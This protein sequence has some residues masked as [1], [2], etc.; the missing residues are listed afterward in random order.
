[1]AV[2]IP[3]DQDRDLKQ[4][5][6]GLLPAFDICPLDLVAAPSAAAPGRMGVRY[7]QP[8]REL[9]ALT[10]QGGVLRWETGASV[11]QF[12]VGGARAGG[13]AALPSG[14][15]LHQFVFE[16]LEPSRIGQT[17]R[18]LDRRLTPTAWID[19][20][21]D[22]GI[23]QG[24]R[25]VQNGR[26][27]AV[28][29]D[30]S[31]AAG[32]RVFLLIHGT[33]SNCE[34]ILEQL[35][36]NPKGV[37]LLTHLERQY[38]FVLAFNHPTVSVSPAMNAFDLAALL[39]PMPK[40]LDIVCHSRGGLV[41]R[42]LCE[43]FADPLT[44]RRVLFVASPLAGT[45]LA[46]PP[47]LRSAMQLLTN[48][49]ECLR[50]ISDFA[51]ANPFFAATSVIMQVLSSLTG[52]VAKTPL[53]D[54]GVAIIPGLTAQ[55]RVGNNEEIERLRR[56]TGSADFKGAKGK[57]HYAAVKAN[58]EPVDPGWHFLQY[59]SKPMQRIAH[60]GADVIFE[61]HN[62]LVVDTAAM[63]EVSD[64]K[65]IDTLWDFGTTAEVNHCNYFRHI[66]TVEAVRKMF[67]IAG[68]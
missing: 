67:Q 36:S 23:L 9:L 51:S 12:R 37:E 4:H 25:R 48:I 16:R 58:F 31:K 32:K 54:A 65:K 53:I 44:V 66:K 43:G 6:R 13:R 45:S 55:S 50:R 24:L 59:F 64:A 38:D 39:R 14:E 68:A 21:A 19:V 57:L 52:I 35:R 3:I 8:Q 22:P 34:N 49:A 60:L 10:R 63:D 26:E 2:T 42:W 18:A 5:L 56:N 61:D 28:P 17:L 7:R 46:A 1:M 27:E 20:K 29:F 33:F 47:R 30:G 41:A 40:Q 11:T 62:D 15:I